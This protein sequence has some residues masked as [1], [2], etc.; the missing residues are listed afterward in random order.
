MIWLLESLVK[1]LICARPLGFATV[2][3]SADVVSSL[4]IR[5]P[6]EALRK[7]RW[8]LPSSVLL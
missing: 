3:V 6:S 2:P 5:V 7:Y 4:R 1:L 8:P